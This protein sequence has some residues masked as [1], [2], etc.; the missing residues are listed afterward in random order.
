MDKR[1]RLRENRAMSK[2]IDTNDGVFA[3]INRFGVVPVV[4]VER[5][6]QALPLAD[7][8]IEGGLPIAEVTFRTAAAAEVI[9]YLVRERPQ[10]LVGA[11]TVISLDNV[12]AAKKSGARFAVAPG[13]N[14][15]VVAE[16]HRMGLAMIPGVATASEIER[17]LSLGCRVLKLFPAALIGGPEMVAALSGPFAH[18]GVKFMPSS[19]VS[20][21]TLSAYLALPTVTAVGGTWIASK[22]AMA[23]GDW[24]TIRARAREA[25]QIV[26]AARR[27]QSSSPEL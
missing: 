19:G 22:D 2:A 1:R 14:P 26:I 23:A 20:G 5:L 18:T 17:G 10:L 25:S 3:A 16:A 21:E 9:D 12:R 7:A 8:L 11:G 27:P 6:E 24:P 13:L 15:E 4:T